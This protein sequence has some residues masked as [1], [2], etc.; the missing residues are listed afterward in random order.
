[1]CFIGKILLLDLF[2]PQKIMLWMISFF[3]LSLS[4]YGYSVNCLA[5]DSFFFFLYNLVIERGIY[6]NLQKAMELGKLLGLFHLL[7]WLRTKAFLDIFLF[8]LLLWLACGLNSILRNNLVFS[9]HKFFFNLHVS[10]T[11]VLVDILLWIFYFEY[12]Y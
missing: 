2:F 12:Y 10:L 8:V 9:I 3:F 6:F 4:V 1:M 5:L 7:P 11:F